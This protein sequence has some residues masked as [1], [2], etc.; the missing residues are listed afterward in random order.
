M[1]KYREAYVEAIEKLK[2]LDYFEE[3]ALDAQNLQN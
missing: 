2:N 3:L 1:R